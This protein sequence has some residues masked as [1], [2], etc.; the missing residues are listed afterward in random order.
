MKTIISIYSFYIFLLLMSGFLV[1]FTY[2]TPCFLR[3]F[4]VSDSYPFLV[5]L[6]FQSSLSFSLS[7]SPSLAFSLFLQ[8]KFDWK[9]IMKL[10]FENKIPLALKLNLG[11]QLIYFYEHNFD[12]EEEKK[13]QNKFCS[14]CYIAHVFLKSELAE[15]LGCF[16]CIL[17]L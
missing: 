4:S 3:F 13:I 7:V 17:Y 12:K 8:L 9:M 15:N 1:F 11:C 6:S 5:F 16:Y 2:L 14:C 10:D